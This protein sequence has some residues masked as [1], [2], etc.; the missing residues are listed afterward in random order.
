MLHSSH[1]IVFLLFPG[2]VDPQTQDTI[3]I[4]RAINRGIINQTKGVYLNPATK[5]VIPI[6]EA[7]SQGLILVEYTNKHI[8]N[9]DIKRGVITTR[10]VKETVS[11][12]IRGVIDPISGETI[13]VAEAVK[14]GVIDQVGIN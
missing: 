7:M 8:E 10:N 12:S 3:S 11:Y 2:V 9:D 1:V 14:L 5:E 4:Y 6:P 13:T